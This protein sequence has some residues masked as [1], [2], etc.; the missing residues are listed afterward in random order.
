MYT[1]SVAQQHRFLRQGPNQHAILNETANP[2]QGGGAKPRV[3][4]LDSRVT[5]L[6]A[7]ANE[8]I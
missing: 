1:N 7:T 5:E 6:S 2:S 4:F 3:Q 8:A